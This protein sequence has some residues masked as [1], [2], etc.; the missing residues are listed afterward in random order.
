MPAIT[1]RPARVSQPTNWPTA[2]AVAAP[3]R[4]PW[5]SNSTVRAPWRAAAM[6][7]T[8]PA[9]PPPL[10]RTSQS[11]GFILETDHT[12]PQGRTGGIVVSESHD[13]PRHAGRHGSPVAC[14]QR[15]RP[16]AHQG[17]DRSLE[18]VVVGADLHRPGEG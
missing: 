11:M 18:A 8:V 6:A 12:P 9:I 13:A 3:P 10:A 7:A 2:P 1:R 16:G 4:K 5:R 17:V 15:G 14:V